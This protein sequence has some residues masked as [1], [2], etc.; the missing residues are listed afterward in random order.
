MIF[1]LK[2]MPL[3]SFAQLL[4]SIS[5]VEEL[6]E[7]HSVSV[8]CKFKVLGSVFVINFFQLQTDSLSL[9]AEG[10]PFWKRK[11]SLTTSVQKR[12]SVKAPP[13]AHEGQCI[14]ESVAAQLLE[15]FPW[16]W[17]RQQN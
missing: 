8:A 15:S 11:K 16:R 12:C 7:S 14:G 5:S 6:K 1:S 13:P 10:L 4:F 17:S 3:L 9:W 2:I